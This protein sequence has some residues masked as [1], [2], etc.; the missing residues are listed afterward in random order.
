MIYKKSN[1]ITQIRADKIL[2]LLLWSITCSYG[3]E[4]NLSRGEHYAN[5]NDITIH[6]YAEGNGPVCLAPSPGWGLSV[7]YLRNTLTEM[8]RYFTMVYYDTRHSGKSSGPEDPL[9]Y[10]SMDFMSDLDALRIYFNQPKV[11]LMG[12]SASGHMVLYYGINHSDNLHGIIALD[13]FAGT[14]SIWESEMNKMIIKRKNEKYFEKAYPR[15]MGKDT[16]KLTEEE[17]F[18]I[19][20]PFYLHVASKADDFINIA[21]LK[22][23]NKVG[24]YIDKNTYFEE[25][26]FD[27][28]YKIT[29]PVLVVVGDDD[30]ICN[31][32]SQADRIASKLRFGT[33]V[34][35]KDAGHFPWF[36]Q[37]IQ[38]NAELRKWVKTLNM[39]K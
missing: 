27:Q 13:A 4:N 3:Q 18:N 26:I 24:K 21:N 37:P 35:I 8:E 9:K 14:D 16:V 28:L 31:R 6:Y 20:L 39:N 30:F 12:H 38:F 36:E 29:V 15:L 22:I 17:A 19:I 32:I 34:V 2:L 11:W 5:I 25:L 7:D 23:D 1:L 33:E 10:T